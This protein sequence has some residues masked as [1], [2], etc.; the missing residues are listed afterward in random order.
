[1]HKSASSEQSSDQKVALEP[2]QPAMEHPRSLQSHSFNDAFELWISDLCER[3]CAMESSLHQED[4]L[5]ILYLGLRDTLL[6]VFLSEAAIS[7][8]VS[9][10]QKHMTNS[11]RSYDSVA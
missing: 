11:G 4:P 3:D 10:C 8:P 7:S 9:S 5:V 1:M 2:V 6:G